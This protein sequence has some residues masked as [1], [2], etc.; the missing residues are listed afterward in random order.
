MDQINRRQLITTI[1]IDNPLKVVAEKN[2]DTI[3]NKLNSIYREK[4]HQGVYITKI[5]KIISKSD[6][7]LARFNLDASG[8]NITVIFTVDTIQVNPGDIVLARLDRKT[9]QFYVLT[10]HN[11]AINI[12]IQGE[13][14]P[15][16]L[17]IGEWCLVVIDDFKSEEGQEKIRA[18]A[19]WFER[20]QPLL[21]NCVGPSIDVSSYTVPAPMDKYILPGEEDIPSVAQKIKAIKEGSWGFWLKGDGTIVHAA[22]T[23]P[24]AVHTEFTTA[25]LM[26]MYYNHLDTLTRISLLYD[27]S[28]ALQ[29]WIARSGK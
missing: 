18:R 19:H 28:P 6:I 3:I 7:T 29:R 25:L 13:E 16:E 10:S 11:N 1:R 23:S 17:S 21:R 8:G 9:P 2:N 22:L 4:C 5:D 12:L 15:H 20:I 27:T 14:P 26:S 24:V